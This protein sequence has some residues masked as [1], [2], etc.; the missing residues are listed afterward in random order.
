M[1]IWQALVIIAMVLAAVGWIV[2]VHA[3]SHRKQVDAFLTQLT[4]LQTD[5]RALMEALA[6]HS[7]Q[8]LIFSKTA[9]VRSEGWWDVK[10]AEST[11]IKVG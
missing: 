11:H 8:P 9:P 1:T 2:Y 4:A 5:N 6:R 10:P 3:A 7:N